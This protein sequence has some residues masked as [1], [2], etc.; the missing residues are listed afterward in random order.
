LSEAGFSESNPFTFEVWYPSS[1]TTRSIVA[2]TMKEAIE[3][4]L[5]GLV[6]VDVQTAESATLWD[7][8]DKGVYPSVLSNWYP[9]YYDADTFIQPFLSCDKG[10]AAAGCEEGAS[11]ANG[12]FYYSENANK[13]VADQRSEQDAAARKEI[14]GELQEVLVEDVPYVPLWQNKDYV[15]AQD[16]VEGVEIQPTQQFLLWQISK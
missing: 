13:L 2:N 3:T 9:D 11:Q 1:S 8:V 4:N 5:P 7:N 16:G 14:F 6:T 15:F 12:S 10:S